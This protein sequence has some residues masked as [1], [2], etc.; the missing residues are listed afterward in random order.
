MNPM[1]DADHQNLHHHSNEE[2]RD[3]RRSREVNLRLKLDYAIHKIA[4][5]VKEGQV[6]AWDNVRLRSY[7]GKLGAPVIEA[8]PG[9]TLNI[10]LDNKLPPETHPGMPNPNIP[11]GFNI[12]NLH[13]HGLHVSPVGNADNVMMAVSPGQKFQYEVNIPSDHPAGLYWYH[14]HK[15]GSVAL[16]VGSGLAGVLIIRGDIDKVPAIQK[17]QEQLFL[18][19]QI[20]YVLNAQ[21]LGE[22]ETYDNFGPGKWDTLNRRITINGRVEP[23]L[24]MK[25]GELQRWRFIHAGLREP[26]LVKLVKRNATTGAEVAVPQY[27]IAL[28]GITTGRIEEVKETELHPGYRADVLVRAADKNGTALPVGTY[29]LVNAALPPERKDRVLA[30]V[31]VRGQVCKMRLP[32]PQELAPLAPFK[33]IGDSELTGTQEA[34]FDIDVTQTPP[35]FLINGRPFDPHAPPRK[36][37]L[38][39]VEEW[40]V[41]SSAITG[42]PFHIHV[43][44]F[45]FTRADGTVVWKDTLFLAAGQSLKLRTRYERYIGTFMLHCHIVDHEDLGMMETLEILPPSMAHQHGLPH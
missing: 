39:A 36:L 14:P 15:H 43:N 18:F 6:L 37:K 16:Q 42:H 3:E 4:R 11:N 44:P 38:G 32:T 7:N 33:N 22:V 20:P 26:L 5:D 12:T 31:V 21:G 41:S 40:T 9:D 27:Q 29:W 45:Q 10:L 30:R 23:T 17:A 25:P 34:H 28:D 35:R 13:F 1:H 2:P 19:Q 8:Y 24:E